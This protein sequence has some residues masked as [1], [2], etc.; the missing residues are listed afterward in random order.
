MKTLHSL[1]PTHLS[2]LIFATL[3]LNIF[4]HFLNDVMHFTALGNLHILFL[5]SAFSLTSRPFV[6]SSPITF[7][8]AR[9]LIPCTDFIP[10]V[11][12]NNTQDSF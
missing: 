4:L 8:Y 11:F 1:C 2:I 6:N 12:L 5:G 9:P 3:L 7:D 10:P